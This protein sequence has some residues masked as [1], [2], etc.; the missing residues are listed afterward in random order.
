MQEGLKEKIRGIVKLLCSL[1]RTP[2][3]SLHV[4]ARYN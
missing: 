4:C 3:Q 1:V 2:L